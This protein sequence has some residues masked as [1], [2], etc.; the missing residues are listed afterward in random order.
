MRDIERKKKK[1]EE[2]KRKGETG[3]M[4]VKEIKERGKAKN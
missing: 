4:T 3:K 1:E 2:R